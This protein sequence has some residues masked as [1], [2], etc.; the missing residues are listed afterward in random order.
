MRLSSTI[1][2]HWLPKLILLFWPLLPLLPT[3]AQVPAAPASQNLAQA[4]AQAEPPKDTVLL[5]VAAEKVIPPPNAVLPQKGDAATQTVQAYG[6]VLRE[7]GGVTAAAPPTM[8]VLNTAPG[9]PNPY[10]GMSV[11]DALKLLLASLSDAQW[12]TLTGPIGL[13]LSDLSGDTQPALFLA[14]FAGESIKLFPRRIVDSYGGEDETNLLSLTP[15]DIRQAHLRLGQRV[16]LG[17]AA[18][19][20]KSSYF[21]AL[22]PSPGGLVKYEIYPGT[23]G[24][25]S[26]NAL[27]GV[28]VRAVV[29]NTPKLSDF[30][31]DDKALGVRINLV[32]V[33]T[34]GDLVQRVGLAVKKEIYADRR[35]ETRSVTYLGPPTARAADLLQALALCVAG[36]YRKVGPAYVLTDDLA[37]EGTRQ[38]IL[39]RFVEAADLA[40]TQSVADAGDSLIT[41]HGIGSLLPLDS[42]ISLSDAQKAD[43]LKSEY[44]IPGTRLFSEV[45]FAKLTPE[46]QAFARQSAETWNTRLDNMPGQEMSE[47]DK[48]KLRVTL[49]KPVDLS[50]APTLLMQTPSV[51]GAIVL[52]AYLAAYSL[53]SPSDQLR[54][55]NDAL[56]QQAQM[57]APPPPAAYVP[58]PA[59]PLGPLLARSPRRAVLISPKTAKEVDAEVA[60]MK[61]VGFNQLWLD[62]FSS[63]KSHLDG[64]SP[65]ILAEAIKQTRG[66]GI[67]VFTVLSLLHWGPEAPPDTWDRTLLGETSPEADAYQT[68]Y[69]AIKFQGKTAEDAEKLTPPADYSVCPFAS[70]VQQ[71]LLALVRRLAATEGV[72][73]MV[74]RDTQAPGYDRPDLSVYGTIG[75]G[76][77]GYAPALRL[78]FLRRTHIDP[79]DLMEAHTNRAQAAGADTSVPDFDDYH[80]ERLA[81]TEW[82]K[83]RADAGRALLQG[84]Y[85]AASPAPARKPVVWIAQ[86]RSTGRDDWYGLWAGPSERLPEKPENVA[87][88]GAQES[89]PAL[90]H[91]QCRADL[92]EIPSF[93]P[94][95]SDLAWML[96]NLPPGWDGF[97]LNL[98][99]SDPDPLARLMPT[100]PVEHN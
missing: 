64:G 42:P 19:N 76:P 69:Q 66:T 98:S 78:A 68:R 2:P 11:G 85:A 55:H 89:I 12:K 56:R 16:T 63:G 82:G 30:V 91:T 65:D 67:Q 88:G 60:A 96:E 36:T 6:R 25:A 9:T 48:V 14:L 97:V 43:L 87:Y 51:N 31:Y 21:N 53:F 99:T 94:T 37:G 8:T 46:Q 29:P 39:S 79:V 3:Q 52:D 73:G 27:F 72:A 77:L 13:G 34:V 26:P 74:L 7:F 33:K 70:A 4:L 50:V 18:A 81:E 23:S 10:D 61:T 95:R 40:R 28:S 86:R 24:S 41:S 83:F 100:S 22:G 15:S 84:I 62:V 71:P 35:Y 17:M 5:T 49:N 44:Y 1:A 75:S 57:A 58:P 20:G 54:A 80:V 59:P 47:E 38:M 92:Y 90:A 32:G 45:P 93:A